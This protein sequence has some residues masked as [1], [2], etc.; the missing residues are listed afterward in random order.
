MVERIHRDPRVVAITE[1][2]MREAPAPRQG[3]CLFCG[4]WLEPD[5]DSFAVALTPHPKEGDT[6]FKSCGDGGSRGHAG[7]RAEPFPRN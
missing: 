6:G 3:L 2:E 1:A 4:T 7:G 5:N